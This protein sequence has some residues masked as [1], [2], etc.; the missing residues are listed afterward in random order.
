[1]SESSS[2]GAS[3][4]ISPRCDPGISVIY[5]RPEGQ[6]P[7]KATEDSDF[8]LG[9]SL[10]APGKAKGVS[11]TCSPELS[12]NEG[13]TWSGLRRDI[14]T[15]RYKKMPHRDSP[16]FQTSVPHKDGGIKPSFWYQKTKTGYKG[17]KF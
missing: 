9:A 11:Q 14:P 8:G 15:V 6:G 4:L 16:Q 7:K 13:E 2:P 10:L 17:A 5:H 3:A 12:W 1:M